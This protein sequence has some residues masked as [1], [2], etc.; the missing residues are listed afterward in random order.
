MSRSEAIAALDL[1]DAPKRRVFDDIVEFLKGEIVSGR[2]RPGDKLKPERELAAQLHVS[3]S[4]LREA[5]RALEMLDVVEINHGQG[6]FVRLPQPS[7]LSK[8]FGTL[9]SMQPGGDED[10]M[11]GRIALDCQAAKLACRFADETDFLRMRRALDRLADP[12][13]GAE[14]QRADADH[15]FHSAIVESTKNATI[16][17]LYRALDVLLRQ[18]HIGR[19]RQ[20]AGRPDQAARLHEAHTAIFL[21]IKSRR[22][23]RA[24]QAMDEHFE[25]I[26]EIYSEIKRENAQ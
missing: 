22:E 17:F 20:L 1:L 19:W 12:A 11:Q 2:L 3:R 21:A 4:S 10:V 23:S 14:L 24:A 7:L 9:L 15:D 5:L 26:R 25:L 8:T 18:S 6:V 16:V 13:A